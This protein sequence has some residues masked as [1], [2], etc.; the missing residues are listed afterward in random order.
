MKHDY[1]VEVLNTTEDL[2][3]PI[4]QFTEELQGVLLSLTNSGEAKRNL[5]WVQ[6]FNKGHYAKAADTLLIHREFM[7]DNEAGI[8]TELT[9]RLGKAS[10][11]LI[12]YDGG[13]GDE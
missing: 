11:T 1:D 8:K 4:N 5:N 10:K 7:D 12:K 2:F 13:F 6:Q 3:G 9:R